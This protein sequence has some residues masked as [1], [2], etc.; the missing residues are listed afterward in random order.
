MG[1]RSLLLLLTLVLWPA[2]R[3]PNFTLP[4]LD[5]RETRLSEVVGERLTLIDF[6]ATWCGPCVKSIPSLV[7]LADSL[8]SE[9][10]NVV[11]VNVDS[12]RNLSKVSPFARSLGVDYPVLLD[13]NSEIMAELNLQAM[14]TLL[15]ID[16]D[17]EIVYIHEGFRAGDEQ[18][19]WDEVEKLLAED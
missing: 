6:W 7:T 4:D 15:V 5:G 18:V 19:V 13:T 9:G 17:R 3:V 14:P 1:F 2:D 11:G 16:A 10:V 8:G 12:P